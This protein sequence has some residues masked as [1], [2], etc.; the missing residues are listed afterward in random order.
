MPRFWW[1]DIHWAAEKARWVEVDFSF[2][3]LCFMNLHLLVL[4][5]THRCISPVTR[6]SSLVIMEY[7]KTRIQMLRW[8]HTYM[9]DHCCALLRLISFSNISYSIFAA[10]WQAILRRDIS[11]LLATKKCWNIRSRLDNWSTDEYHITNDAEHWFMSRVRYRRQ[12]PLLHPNWRTVP[13]WR[14][15]VYRCYCSTEEM[16]CAVKLTF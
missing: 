8:V 11:E 14:W 13:E 1:V 7:G 16:S 4:L 10:I 12:P 2:W 15:Y 3:T 9:L 5:G 6:G